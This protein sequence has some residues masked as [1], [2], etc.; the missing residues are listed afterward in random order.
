MDLLLFILGF[1]LAVVSGILFILS[2]DNENVPASITVL[3]FCLAFVCLALSN[4]IA[5][6]NNKYTIKA[7]N[8]TLKYDTVSLDK[9]GKLFE[10]KIK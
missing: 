10:I 2:L 9:S 6:K 3:I 8:G 1:V 5:E 7:L 4:S